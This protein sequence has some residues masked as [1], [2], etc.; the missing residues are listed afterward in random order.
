M[1]QKDLL[2]MTIEELK[3]FADVLEAAGDFETALHDLIK[4]TIIEH[5]RIIFNGNGYDD[6]WIAEAERR[7]LLNLKSTP[8]CLPYLLHEKN[9]ELFSKH[10]VY[11]EIELRSRYEI[12]L[13]NY[14]KILNIEALTMIDMVKKDILPSVSRYIHEL[15]DT[16]LAK[17][18]F[19]PL[20]DC[21]Y[22]EELITK[23]SLLT[24]TTYTNVKALE[25]A[26]MDAGDITD[27]TELAKYYKDAVFAAMNELRI[28]VDELETLTDSKIW[29]YPSYG[30]L[31]F[32]V[33]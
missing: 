20:S 23:L 7:G 9:I 21:S 13:E 12:I 15:S 22:E 8:D 29:P 28:G 32:S 26:L 31:L 6:S 27:T 24:G 30:D 14:S 10:R 1:E 25:K 4:K 16:A 3:Q 19:A 17:K 18:S 33:K 5:K 11:S 2:G